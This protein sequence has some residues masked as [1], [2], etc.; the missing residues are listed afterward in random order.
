MNGGITLIFTLGLAVAGVGILYV[1]YY[2]TSIS[3]SVNDVRAQARREMAAKE[4]QLREAI[5]D[6]LEKRSDWALQQTEAAVAQLRAELDEEHAAFRRETV[7]ALE[8]LAIQVQTL[9]MRLD[10]VAPATAAVAESGDNRDKKGRPQGT[11]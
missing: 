2:V 11:A 3:N 4:E 1:L 8:N 9:Q 10:A 7:K 6:S 5:R